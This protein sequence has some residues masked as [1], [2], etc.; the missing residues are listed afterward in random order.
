MHQQDFRHLYAQLAS[1]RGCCL[2]EN[3]VLKVGCVGLR[4]LCCGKIKEVQLSM[5]SLQ[6]IILL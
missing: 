5:I 1:L 2:Y 4:F 6:L 3:V